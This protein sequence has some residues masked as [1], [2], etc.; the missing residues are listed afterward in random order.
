MAKDKSLVSIEDYMCK[1]ESIL[2]LDDV[3]KQRGITSRILKR[4]G[5]SVT[6]V[7][8]GEAAV[9]YLRDN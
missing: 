5:C 9:D 2:V 6:S 3:E 1:G 7:S 4:L 8:N